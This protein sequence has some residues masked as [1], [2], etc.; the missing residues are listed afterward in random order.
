MRRLVVSLSWALT[1]LALPLAAGAQAGKVP[2]IGFLEASSPRP[3][4][5]APLKQ[6]LR[7]LGHVEGQT[8]AFRVQALGV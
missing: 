4:L 2:C 7:E 5:W 8:I 3:E 6:R 1:L